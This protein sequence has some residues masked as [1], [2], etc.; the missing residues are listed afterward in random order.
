MNH[1][2]DEGL[3][4]LLPPLLELAR[5]VGRAV[6]ALYD[7]ADDRVVE[8]KTDDSPLT[9]ADW[10]AHHMIVDGLSRLTHDWP[11]L[12]E[13]SVAV[14]YAERSRW[15]Q[16]WLVDPL[17]GTKEFLN[18]NGEFTINIALIKHGVPVL[19]VVHAPANE[20]IYFAAKGQGAFCQVGK[21]GPRRLSAKAWREGETMKIVASRSHG[22]DR[23]QGLMKKYEDYEYVSM[24]SSLK[25]CLVA[26]GLAHVYPRFGCTMEWDTAA[27]HCVVM[28]ADGA[29]CDFRGVELRY[30]KR[31]LHNPPF[32][33][34][35]VAMKN[36]VTKILE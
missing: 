15:P 17:D 35:A 6:M 10:V 23:L 11:V 13:E 36:Q 29:A 2:S 22:D 25:M 9:K 19:G 21:E 8:Y 27:A 1:I 5:E 28:E 18:C 26:E 33:V 30:N 24:G 14:S 7:A 31:D 3:T 12:S 32:I 34:L 4:D 16:F 20:A